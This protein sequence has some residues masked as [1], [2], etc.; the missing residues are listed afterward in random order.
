VITPPVDPSTWVRKAEPLPLSH[1]GPDALVRIEAEQ[2]VVQFERLDDYGRRVAMAMM[3]AL[4]RLKGG[5][6]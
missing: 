6:T 4:T 2:M 1:I 5:A 3:C